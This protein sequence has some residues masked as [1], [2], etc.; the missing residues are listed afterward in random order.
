M[1]VNDKDTQKDIANRDK[2]QFTISV[3]KRGNSDTV[4]IPVELSQ[5][6]DLEKGDKVIMQPENGEYGKYLSM[7]KKESEEENN[8]K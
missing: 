3:V 7:W 2:V 1:N 6:L 4:T 5:Y 8:A